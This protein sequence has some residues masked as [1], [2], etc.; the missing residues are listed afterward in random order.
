MLH[1]LQV[2]QHRNPTG[3]SSR[4]SVEVFPGLHGFEDFN[5]AVQTQMRFERNEIPS[6]SFMVSYVD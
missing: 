1:G 3:T 4:T 5:L 2:R 6:K